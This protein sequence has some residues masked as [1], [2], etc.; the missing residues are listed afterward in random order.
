WGDAT[1]ALG[2]IAATAALA[3]NRA[4][5]LRPDPMGSPFPKRLNE[6]LVNVL[7]GLAL[8][9]IA[10][11]GVYLRGLV[12]PLGVAVIAWIGYRRA[13]TLDLTPAYRFKFWLAGIGLGAAMIYWLGAL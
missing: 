8:V 11:L 13:L 10:T 4:E 2:V 6:M 3:V 12:L 5:V 9:M 7:A 1:S